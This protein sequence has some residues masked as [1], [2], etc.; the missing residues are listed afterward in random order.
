[1]K[2][3]EDNSSQNRKIYKKN[4]LPFIDSLKNWIESKKK[5]TLNQ[6]KS[7]PKTIQILQNKERKLEKNIGNLQLQEF[8]RKLQ[9]IS[10]NKCSFEEKSPFMEFK[11]PWDLFKPIFY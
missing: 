5:K 7:E 10:S 11:L 2:E 9:M 1:M 3:I 8:E 4:I 6:L